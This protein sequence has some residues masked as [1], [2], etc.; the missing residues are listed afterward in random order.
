[1]LLELK[2]VY[3]KGGTNGELSVDGRKV[4]STIELPWK[5]NAKSISCIP[6]GRYKVVKHTSPKFGLVAALTGVTGRDAILIHTANNAQRELQGCIA[7]VSYLTGEGLGM[8][9]K[10]AWEDV[11]DCVYSAWAKK[12]TV[13]IVISKAP[14]P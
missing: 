9:S 1:M 5:D 7:P 12:E 11:M 8:K 10:M 13:E 2:R 4:C 14:M 6:E 3:L